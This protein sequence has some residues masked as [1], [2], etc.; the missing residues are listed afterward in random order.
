MKVATRAPSTVTR[1]RCALYRVPLKEPV[2]DAK[3]TTGRQR[4]LGDVDVVVAHVATADGLEGLG[5]SY[6]K[7]AGGPALFAHA[8]Q[9]APLLVGEDAL[10]TGRIWEK[11][12]W[13]AA[14]V[15]RQG[16]AVQSLAAFDVAL[17]DRK[18]KLAGISLA[19]LL[20][21]HRDAVRCYDTT[22]G[23]LSA[24]LETV[25]AASE[26]SLARG[27]GG[28][29]LK[30]GGEPREDVARVAALRK[31]LGGDVAI[32][33][34]AN[35]AWDRAAAKRIGRRLEEYELT[36]IEE[37]LDAYDVKGHAALRDALDTPI[38]TG[39]MLSSATDLRRLLEADAVDVIQPDA[40]RIGGIT[41]Y[42]RVSDLADEL[43]VTVAPHFATQLHVH[44][45]AGQPREGWVEWFDWLDPLFEERVELRDGKVVVP[46][47]PGLGLTVS[48]RAGEWLLSA[49]DLPES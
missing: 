34:D 18:A 25:I 3:V 39:E 36:W 49:A 21:S 4:P 37:P 46:D 28:I 7:R 17:H 20:G 45:A 24:K 8:K 33:V 30:V 22:V 48:P 44:L 35:Q 9:I 6:S 11:L 27:M 26:R 1:V 19:K 32:M 23:F 29:K 13:A 2:S 10:D 40:V 41:P 12:L 47:R 15:G 16:V 43:G 42:R 5:F 14:S 31:A 38:A